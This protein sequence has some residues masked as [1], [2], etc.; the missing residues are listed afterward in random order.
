MSISH[1][2]FTFKKIFNLFLFKY[3]VAAPFNNAPGPGPINNAPFLPTRLPSDQEIG[4]TPGTIISDP[5]FNVGL[6]PGEIYV[7]NNGKRSQKTPPRRYYN[8]EYSEYYSSSTRPYQ[9]YYPNYLVCTVHIFSSKECILHTEI[10]I[11]T[12]SYRRAIQKHTLT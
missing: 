2:H 4:I 3:V 12:T 11:F 10:L 7:D 6:H 9:T 8:K 1:I 5:N